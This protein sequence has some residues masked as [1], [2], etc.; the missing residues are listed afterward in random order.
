MAPLAPV[1]ILVALNRMI[2]AAREV[3]ELI[4]GLIYCT[5]V[6]NRRVIVTL[7]WLA[8][9]MSFRTCGNK[10]DLARSTACDIT[11]LLLDR[12]IGAV[13]QVIKSPDN[14]EMVGAIDGCQIYFIC[15]PA[16][17]NREYI[18]RKLYYSINLQGLVDHNA[19][20]I[21]IC[22]GCPGSCYDL[23]V[24]RHS[25]LYREAAY[26]PRGFFIIDDGG[27]TCLRDP[28]T[29][30]NPYRDDR[31]N[32]EQQSLTTISAKQE[33]WWRELSE[34]YKQGGE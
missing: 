22:V 15:D 34:C 10:F 27:Y 3:E 2:Q 29:L 32:E 17:R 19:R 28:I 16:E 24:L 7:Y 26:P 31:L 18:N 30:I 12:I 20:F 14:V 23:R 8:A 1:G 21:N 5:L 33:L 6:L 9:G 25:G 11:E 4:I 13:N